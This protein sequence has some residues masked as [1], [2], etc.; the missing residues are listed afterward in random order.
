MPSPPT[1]SAI[2]ANASGTLGSGTWVHPRGTGSTMFSALK[3]RATWGSSLTPLEWRKSV[4]VTELAGTRVC[5]AAAV[6]AGMT[7]GPA[8]DWIPVPCEAA[9]APGSA[10]ASWATV[11]GAGCGKYG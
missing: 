2:T 6:A 1:R 4:S 5:C 9:A 10:G 11:A 3:S 7:P 8:S